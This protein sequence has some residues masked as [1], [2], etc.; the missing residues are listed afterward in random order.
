MT[1]HSE[2]S[3]RA[4]LPVHDVETAPGAGRAAL[5][6]QAV[7]VGKVIN[8]FGTMANSPA[9]MNVYDLV[10]SHL[11]EHS[12][13]DNATRQAIH[14]TVAAVNDCDYCQAAY[15]GA[16]KSAGFTVEETIA[17]RQGAL[18]DHPKLQALITLTRQIADNRGYVDETVWS[19]TLEAGWSEEEI[20]DAYT[21]VVRTIL[22][23][24]FNH[25]V[26]T[27]LDLPPAP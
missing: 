3:T 13:L 21:D 8:I 22:T 5:A 25:L 24:Y 15:T 4:R 23:N 12:T 14:L 7:R 10:E 16:A 2:H 6:H 20:L 27:E 18:G 11:A 9:L 19:D 26:G 1:A 17:I